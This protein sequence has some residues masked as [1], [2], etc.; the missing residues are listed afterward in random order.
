MQWSQLLG[1]N[2]PTLVTN[3]GAST[4][5]A[6]GV[7][8]HRLSCCQWQGVWI[9]AA[10]STQI[11][12]SQRDTQS[13]SRGISQANTCHCPYKD[14]AGLRPEFFPNPAIC[15]MWERVCIKPLRTQ[16]AA[17]LCWIRM[18]RRRN[19]DLSWF[20]GNVALI[21]TGGKIAGCIRY[22]IVVPISFVHRSKH[23]GESQF[24]IQLS[25]GI[26]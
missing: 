16:Q 12:H 24:Y 13:V 8:S 20:L 23:D 17:S 21:H 1:G 6:Q 15:Q 4:K 3:Q 25:D 11:Y 5:G 22:E 7:T 14:K 10:P 9:Q 26:A 19:A 18:M 2:Q